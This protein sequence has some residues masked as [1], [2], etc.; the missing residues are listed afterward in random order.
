M[1]DN[2]ALPRT[3]RAAVP[4]SSLPRWSS[5]RARVSGGRSDLAWHGRGTTAAPVFPPLILAH[6]IC[7]GECELSQLQREKRR[8]A[9]SILDNP[10]SPS[11][12]S[13]CPKPAS[14]T[15][16]PPARSVARVA[17]PS[18]MSS[19]ANTPSTCTRG[20]VQFDEVHGWLRHATAHMLC[21]R[22]PASDGRLRT[23]V[24]SNTICHN[25]CTVFPSRS[26]PRVPSR[27]SAPSLSRP[28]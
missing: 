2:N 8:P 19:P 6:T 20:Y 15:S 10:I 17:A 7:L 3:K 23:R 18:R 5:E 22:C 21:A 13:P 12:P 28:W 9:T 11:I 16:P 25:R 4:W 24:E 14:P 26:A 1:I 27:R